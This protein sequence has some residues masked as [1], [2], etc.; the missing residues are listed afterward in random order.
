MKDNTPEVVICSCHS[1]EHQMV[2]LPMDEIEND[3]I[4]DKT[5]YVH[6]HL[7]KRPFWKRV[8][9]AW[10]YILGHQSKYGSFDEFIIDQSN[11]HKFKDVV[12]YFEE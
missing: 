6:V 3:K 12:K 9:V 8:K 4:I 11:Y 10:K 7:N 1:T 2:F 5:I